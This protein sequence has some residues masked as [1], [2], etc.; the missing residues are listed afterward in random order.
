MLSRALEAS[1]AQFDREQKRKSTEDLRS[2][3]F[4]SLV[5]KFFL[6]KT[7]KLYSEILWPQ[8]GQQGLLFLRFFLPVELHQ[9][10][11][12]EGCYTN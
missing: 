2:E 6:S 5:S 12:F 4:Q 1:M 7:S 8:M 3:L 10:L 11:T 9:T